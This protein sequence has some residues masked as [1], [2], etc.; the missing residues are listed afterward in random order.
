MNIVIILRLKKAFARP[1]LQENRSQPELPTVSCAASTANIHKKEVQGV[2]TGE[3]AQKA[4][5]SPKKISRAMTKTSLHTIHEEIST[6][7]QVTNYWERKKITTF[8]GCHKKTGEWE[9]QETE[10]KEERGEDDEAVDHH[11]D[12][13]HLAHQPQ[14][15][16]R[17]H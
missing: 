10:T 14:L 11:H 8:S 15:H 5:T 7:S 16:L 12:Q 1:S 9:R 17:H 3:K 2:K 13:L 4:D 6:V